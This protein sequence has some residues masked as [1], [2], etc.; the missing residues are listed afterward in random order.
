V[1]V[2]FACADYDPML[3]FFVS[4][5]NR[6][7]SNDEIWD[8]VLKD[9]YETYERKEIYVEKYY[10]RKRQILSLENSGYNKYYINQFGNKIKYIVEYDGMFPIDDIQVI[11]H[12]KF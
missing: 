9:K 12:K 2:T 11:L 5:N 7:Y 6:R 4:G 3:I 10:L 1:T 8:T